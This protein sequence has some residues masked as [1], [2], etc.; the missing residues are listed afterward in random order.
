M[1]Y[2]QVKEYKGRQRIDINKKDNMVADSEVVILTADEYDTLKNKL[3][4][5][6]DTITGMKKELEIYQNQ[7][8]S[9]K[10]IIEDVNAPIHELY[11]KELK[12]KDDYISQLEDKYKTLYDKAGQY[13]LELMG[14]NGFEILF[15]RKHK[16]LI[17]TFDADMKL[18]GKDADIVT[19]DIVPGGT[20]SSASEE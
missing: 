17:K 13:N 18:I 2:K 5:M 7:E 3:L 14:L 12:S 8:Q 11:K 19:T 20:G 6:Q 15:F 16:K 9:L 10:E 4:T 1:L